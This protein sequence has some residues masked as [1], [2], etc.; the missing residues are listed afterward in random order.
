[1]SLQVSGLNVRYGK[2]HVVFDLDLEV[3][4]GEL[5]TLLGRNGAGKTT[6]ILGVVGLLPGATGDVRVAGQPVSS[7][8]PYRRT[9]GH[10][11]YVPSGARCFPNLTVQ[12][13]LELTAQRDGASGWDLRRVFELFPRL[14]QLRANLAGGLSGGERQMLAV[15]RAL[16]S[17]PRVLL[18]DEPTEGLAPVVVQSITSLLR[19]LKET[20]VSILLAEQNHQVALR[21]ADR[22]AFLEKGRIVDVLPADRARGSEVLHRILGV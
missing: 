11:A 19:A 3:A 9:K 1:M 8:P 16:M 17:N 21:V 12:E 5:V 22:A 10:L 20:G 4:A 13:N 18:L 14:E 2:S 15:G 7:W 6:T